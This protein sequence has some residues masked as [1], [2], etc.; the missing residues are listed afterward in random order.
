V[1]QE[2]LMHRRPVICSDVGGMA[3]RV[4]DGVNGLH[5]R[6]GDP[7]SLADTIR[8]AVSTPGLWDELRAGITDPHSM[9]AHLKVI[10]AI[11]R[12]LLERGTA[13]APAAA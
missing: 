2:A 11:Y 4:H 12:E 6:V 13:R 3:E 9:D 8:R 10:S 1:I 7:S 5:F